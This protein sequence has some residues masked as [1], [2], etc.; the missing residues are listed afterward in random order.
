MAVLIAELASV[1]PLPYVCALI[2]VQIVVRLG[3]P[4]GTPAVPPQLIRR[5]SGMIPPGEEDG[6]GGA[7][8]RVAEEVVKVLLAEMARLPAASRDL[9]R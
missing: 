1:V 3:I 8:G 6:G 9:T 5:L 7:G 4:P 2:V